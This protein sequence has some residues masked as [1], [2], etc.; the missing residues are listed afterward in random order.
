MKNTLII[1][2]IIITIAACERL[3][4]A[5]VI[6]QNNT[7]YYILIEANSKGEQLESIAIQPNDSYT[8]PQYYH[9]E[10]GTYVKLFEDDWIDSV[11]IKF[12]NERIIIQNCEASQLELCSEV[13]RNIL[14]FELYYEYE[15]LG[16]K[17]RQFTYYITKDDYQRAV[18][19]E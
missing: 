7:E 8:V 10:D 6:I 3:Y 2:G 19:I 1:I 4:Y 13:E 11:I 16:R 15:E 12:N 5:E 18:P 9:P 17:E 14:L